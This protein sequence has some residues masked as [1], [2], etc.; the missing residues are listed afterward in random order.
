LATTLKIE[1]ERLVVKLAG[2]ASAQILALMNAIYLRNKNSK[3]FQLKYYPYSTGTYWPFA[4]KFLLDDDELLDE[5]VPTVGLKS[6]ADL[7]VGKIIRSHPLAAKRFSYEHILSLIR[8]LNLEEPLQK[9]RG[10]RALL[11]SINKLDKVTRKVL[12]VSGGF[13]PILDSKV[14]Q[15]MDARFKMARIKSPFSKDTSFALKVDAVIHY[16]IGDKRAKFSHPADFGGDG[17][18]DPMVFKNI[19]ESLEINALDSVYVVSDEPKIAQALLAQIGISAAL[20][21]VQGDIWEDLYFISQSKVFIGSWSQVSQLASICV[22][23][24][25]GAAYL[26]STTQVGTKIK[27]NIPDVKYFEPKFLDESHAIYKP[28]FDLDA[29]AHSSYR[30]NESKPH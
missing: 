4:I 21:P 3:N 1:H 16:R 30:K 23:G 5:N 12:T 15:E 18:T 13:V 27:W 28:D 19:L 7:P 6:T 24:N 9:F 10:E 8:L 25:G 14:N 11:A 17:I 29:S 22:I 2:G 20:N 26:P